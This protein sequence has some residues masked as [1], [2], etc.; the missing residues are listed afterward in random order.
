MRMAENA[1]VFVHRESPVLITRVY[2]AGYFKRS[3]TQLHVQNVILQKQ[4][5]QIWC[6]F[7]FLF[8]FE[9]STKP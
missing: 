8:S 5:M 2:V 6:D 9:M 4:R 1:K 3:L 7:F